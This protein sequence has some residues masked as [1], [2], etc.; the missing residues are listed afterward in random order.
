[1]KDHHDCTIYLSKFSKARVR[2]AAMHFPYSELEMVYSI[3]NGLPKHGAWPTF[4]MVIFHM[5]QAHINEQ[6]VTA[7]PAAPDTLLNS[8]IAAITVESQ[9]LQSAEP[10]LKKNGPGPEYSM[11]AFDWHPMVLH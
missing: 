10:S 6:V 4:N 5:M 11:S 2:F 7:I 1:M 9:H 3:I 8:V